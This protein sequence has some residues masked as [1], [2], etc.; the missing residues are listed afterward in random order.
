MAH[1]GLFALLRGEREGV[2]HERTLRVLFV[3]FHTWCSYQGERKS[4]EGEA[5]DGQLRAIYF[6]KFVM[7]VFRL[8]DAYF[9]QTGE[10]LMLR[11][12]EMQEHELDST[13]SFPCPLCEVKGKHGRGRALYDG[14]DKP[15]Y[16]VEILYALQQENILHY[17][18]V[19]P[20]TD[21][22]DNPRH[23]KTVVKPG[24]PTFDRQAV[25]GVL[26]SREIAI[27]DQMGL[28]LRRLGPAQ[29]RA[30]GTH[31]N[32]EK[33]LE[34]V[35]KEFEDSERLG[36]WGSLIDAIE[37]DSD[38]WVSS[39]QLH[40]YADE[41]YRKAV[42]NRAA[43]EEARG[44]LETEITDD[45]LKNVFL[46]CQKPSNEVWSQDE[47]AVHDIVERSKKFHA[48]TLYLVGLAY[49]SQHPGEVETQ[50]SPLAEN[51]KKEWLSGRTSLVSNGLDKLPSNLADCFQGQGKLR[52]VVRSRLLEVVRT[53]REQ[54]CP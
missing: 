23:H 36:L 40:E 25:L 54:V 1:G 2:Q 17:F 46:D 39:E 3:L 16:I 42:L 28:F 31:E 53:V 33:T 38:F 13:I 49:F 24:L 8:W 18:D 35:R 45:D 6:D 21:D 26:T 14:K 48:L 30:L 50:R 22:P 10:H 12:D 5:V 7:V 52:D 11:A 4:C 27:V 32:R 15:A 19:R 44:L 20:P 9:R 51:R 47:R 37:N 41:A 29:I 43:Y 34:D